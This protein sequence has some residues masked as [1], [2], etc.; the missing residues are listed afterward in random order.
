MKRLIITAIVLGLVFGAGLALADP[1]EHV[2]AT[3]T[4]QATWTDPIAPVHKSATG[5]LNISVYGATWSATVT[6]QRRFYHGA[7]TDWVDVEEFTENSEKQLYDL[8]PKCQYRIGVDT[9]DWTSGSVVV[10]L[11]K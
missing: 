8:E 7:W 9:G 1:H 5:F 11:S 6:L 10:R 4:A 2:S 3:I